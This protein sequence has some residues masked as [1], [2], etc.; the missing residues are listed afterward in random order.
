MKGSMDFIRLPVARP[1]RG[2][3]ANPSLLFMDACVFPSITCCSAS[4]RSL[5]SPSLAV[6]RPSALFSETASFSPAIFRLAS[7]SAFPVER[8]S[9]SPRT[10][11]I[12]FSSSVFLWLSSSHMPSTSASRLLLIVWGSGFR[13]LCF[14]IQCLRFLGSMV[15]C[16]SSRSAHAVGFMILSLGS[17][18]VML[19]RNTHLLFSSSSLVLPN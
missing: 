15:Y 2:R 5:C 16:H 8:A 12:S 14:I 9:L 4:S 19:G 6:L 11:S 1:R 3:H 7:T 17:I 18:D 10:P 13:T